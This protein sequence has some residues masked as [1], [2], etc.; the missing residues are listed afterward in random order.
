MTARTL[1]PEADTVAVAGHRG[2][3]PPDDHAHRLLE[4]LA[5]APPDHATRS[6]LRAEVIEAWLPLGRQLA[7]RYAGRGEPL[8]DLIQTA[9]IGLI[10]AVDRYEIS[11][12][13]D[14][15]AFAVPTV[16][17]EIRRHFRDRTWQLRV[18]RRLQ[19][20]RLAVRDSAD[21]LTQELGHAPS[22]DEVAAE[23]HLSP[24]EVVEGMDAARAFSTLSL[25]ASV[26]LAVDGAVELGELVGDEDPDLA[27]VEL[28][29]T[30]AAALARLPARE[31]R[32][33]CLRF[34]GNKT[35]S[36]I[37]AEMGISQMH[38]SRLLTR[39]LLALREGITDPP[40]GPG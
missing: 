20:L 32:I 29:M 16:L 26:S 7:R 25:D 38:V 35:Q 27:F 14:F 23:L 37:A 12:G 17:G 4:R 31:Q 18:P 28:R 30:L 22:A 15:L 11:R 21:E 9:T 5:A 39:S 3:G 2:V 24:D 8:D 34:Y 40:G 36:E 6:R 1:E 10:K 33:L 19:E 13:S